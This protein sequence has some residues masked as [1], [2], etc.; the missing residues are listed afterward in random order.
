MRLGISETLKRRERLIKNAIEDY[1]TGLFTT[2]ELHEALAFVDKKY[3]I[4]EARVEI[5][6]SRAEYN[7]K[8]GR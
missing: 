1:A 7:R 3:P 8:F 2:D 6:K 4:S 5:I